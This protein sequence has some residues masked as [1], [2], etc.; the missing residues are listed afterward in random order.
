[1]VTV[2]RI[3]F[4]AV[5]GWVPERVT[6]NVLPFGLAGIFALI[7]LLSNG[8]PGL[9]VLLFGLA[10]LG[11]SA[12]LPLTIGFAQEELA[13]I[14]AAAAGGIIAFYQLGYGIAAF[15]VGPLLDAGV[16][17]RAVYAAAAGIAVAMGCCPSGW[18]AASTRIAAPV[19]EVGHE[20]EG[21]RGV[22]HDS[23]YEDLGLY[24]LTSTRLAM[25]RIE[26]AR[27]KS[28][29]VPVGPSRESSC[30][31]AAWLSSNDWPRVAARIA[32]WT[33]PVA[34]SSPCLSMDHAESG[35]ERLSSG[36]TEDMKVKP[37]RRLPDGTPGPRQRDRGTAGGRLIVAVWRPGVTRGS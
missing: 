10:G 5:E 37:R 14:A 28:S 35:F 8:S 9:G 36:A 30:G 15:G 1:M 34:E 18:L 33:L 12:L 26:I 19:A 3:V 32:S 31:A 24:R 17:L 13:A 2:G 27:M 29:F 11:C 7:A 16:T 20:G 22:D 4:A 21:Q 25:R 6:Y 23:Q